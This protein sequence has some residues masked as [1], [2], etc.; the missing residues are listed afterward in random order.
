[1]IIQNKKLYTFSFVYYKPSKRDT[2]PSWEYI[3]VIPERSKHRYPTNWMHGKCPGGS[4]SPFGDEQE[5][6][7]VKCR[8]CGEE[9]PLYIKNQMLLRSVE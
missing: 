7:T 1:M 2:L 3:Y 5:D 6:G 4:L 9:L 8:E